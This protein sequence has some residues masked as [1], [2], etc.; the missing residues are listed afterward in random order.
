GGSVSKVVFVSV[1]AGCGFASAGRA[2]VGLVCCAGGVCACVTVKP[3]AKNNTRQVSQRGKK[4][5]MCR[6]GARFK[7]EP[8]RLQRALRRVSNCARVSAASAFP[9]PVSQ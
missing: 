3:S 8:T 7:T 4:L 5:L 1:V 2:G 9:L 6:D